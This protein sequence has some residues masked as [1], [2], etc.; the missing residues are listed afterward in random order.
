MVLSIILVD[1]KLGFLGVQPH[2][3][4]MQEPTDARKSRAQALGSLTLKEF[5]IYATGTM[6]RD[7]IYQLFK[8]GNSLAVTG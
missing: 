6:G 3:C 1:A 5:G 7:G 8:R 2:R 4:L